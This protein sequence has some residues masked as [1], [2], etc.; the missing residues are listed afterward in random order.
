MMQKNAK[1]TDWQNQRNPK[2]EKKRGRKDGAKNQ[3]QSQRCSSVNFCMPMVFGHSARQNKSSLVRGRERKQEMGRTEEQ[4]SGSTVK[5]GAAPVSACLIDLGE[6]AEGCQTFIV[7][8]L[9]VC[10][11]VCACTHSLVSHFA[12][13]FSVELFLLFCALSRPLQQALSCV[14]AAIAPPGGPRRIKVINIAY[15]QQWL[16][17]SLPLYVSLFPSP[18]GYCCLAVI[19]AAFLPLSQ[20]PKTLTLSHSHA[21]PLADCTNCVLFYRC[22]CLRLC[23]CFRLCRFYCCF[24]C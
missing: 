8:V 1:E 17:C 13:V 14:S 11:L 10:V 23:C 9:C 12:N 16:L 2:M 3:N 20:A 19:V 4:K 24:V 22:R 7:F 18:S 21:L 15:L 6:N 5:T